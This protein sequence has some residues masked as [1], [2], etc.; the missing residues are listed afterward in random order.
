MS[1]TRLLARLDAFRIVPLAPIGRA[2]AALL[3]LNS[4][5]RLGARATL[6]QI[7]LNRVR[8]EIVITGFIR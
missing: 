4:P 2:A 8:G 7:V 5:E 3:R 1:A 6:R